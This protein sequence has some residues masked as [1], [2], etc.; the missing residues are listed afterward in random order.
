MS[1]NRYVPL[2]FALLLV[3]VG[4]YSLGN[5]SRADTTIKADSVVTHI[6]V[7]SNQPV[8]TTNPTYTTTPATIIIPDFEDVRRTKLIQAFDKMV[9]PTDGITTKTT[10]A[11]LKLPEEVDLETEDRI[12]N[13]SIAIA[14]VGD[15]DGNG[16]NEIVITADQGGNHRFYDFRVYSCSD[17]K[18][19]RWLTVNDEEENLQAAILPNQLTIISQSYEMFRQKIYAYK[20]LGSG[21]KLELLSDV[22]KLCPSRYISCL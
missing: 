2:I 8:A 13:S 17:T 14:A 3:S 11:M 16:I 7:S 6:P 9:C 20:P 4:S 19:V 22:K 5:F 10:L 21:D 15:I 12:D 1:K 18:P